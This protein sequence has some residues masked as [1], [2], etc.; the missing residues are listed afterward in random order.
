MNVARSPVTPFHPDAHIAEPPGQGLTGVQIAERL[1]VA[2]HVVKFHLA[3]VC[4][5]LRLA[6]RTGA[7]VVCM[8]LRRT[9]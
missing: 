5:K 7:A 6:N 3:L 8:N 2:S 9:S 1:A 4:R